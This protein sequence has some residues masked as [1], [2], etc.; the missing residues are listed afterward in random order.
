ME[1]G[2]EAAIPANASDNFDEELPEGASDDGLL[3]IVDDEQT[4]RNTV[5]FWSFLTKIQ[6]SAYVQLSHNKENYVELV[7]NSL[8]CFS[9]LC[10][11][12]KI[13]QIESVIIRSAQDDGSD[14]A[15][16]WSK[17]MSY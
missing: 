11:I 15:P 13:K 3:A 5:G 16:E 9:A 12:G 8:N 4:E 7:L 10:S 2:A 17:L 14:Q 6:R 1:S